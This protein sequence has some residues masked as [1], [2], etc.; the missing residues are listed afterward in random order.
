M[1]E[2]ANGN[3]TLLDLAK[4]SDP[5][6]SIGII[7]EV[8]DK[9]NAVVSDINFIQ[10]NLTT[11]HRAIIRTGIPTPTWRMFNQNV[12]PTKSTTAQVDFGT[13]MLENYSSMD[14]ALAALNGNARAA[15]FSEDSAILEGIGQE[16]ATTLFYGNEDLN[17]EEFT[18]LQYYYNDENS[19]SA[20]NLING[21]GSGS[22]VD[23]GSIYLIGW[24]DRSITGIIPKEGTPGI[25]MNDKGEQLIGNDTD[26]FIERFITHFKML[27]GLAV[28]DWRFGVRIANIRRGELNADA[29]GNSADLPD[30]MFTAMERIQSLE[31]VRPVFYMDRTMLEFLRKQMASKVGNSTLEFKDVGGHRAAMFQGVPVRRT[32]ALATTETLVTFS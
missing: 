8:L 6:G 24:G 7:T 15:R 18:G 29:S 11:G 21:A 30:L 2:L 32:D 13:G 9:Q 14:S 4:R 12:Q 19:E 31:G 20:D 10:G 3:L 26:G 23:Y 5:N 22:D 16:I 1:A 17:P 27:A 28:L 25:Q